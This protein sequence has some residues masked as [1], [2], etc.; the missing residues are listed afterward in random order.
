MGGWD[1]KVV[2]L[3]HA[4][5]DAT[6]ESQGPGPGVT[7]LQEDQDEGS[8]QLHSEFKPRDEYT[9]THTNAKDRAKVICEP[10]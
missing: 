3:A 6:K 5:R 8:C 10:E 4:A 7:Y 2:V 9:H 1:V